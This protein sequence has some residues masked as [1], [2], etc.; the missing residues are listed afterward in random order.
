[1]NTRERLLKWREL[2]ETDQ[3]AARLFE[4][5]NRQDERFTSL[6]EFH[7]ELMDGFKRRLQWHIDQRKKK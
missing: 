1:M 6:I 5:Q 3:P 4:E 2:Y 7:H